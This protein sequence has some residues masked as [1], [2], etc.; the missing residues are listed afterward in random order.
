[1][2]LSA[3]LINYNYGRFLSEALD[4]LLNQT[5]KDYDVVFVDDAST[6]NSM[7]IA[8]K[9]GAIYGDR[10]K[11]FQNEKN[12]GPCLTIKRAVSLAQGE[13]VAM[14]A[15]DDKW[16][17]TF[18]EEVMQRTEKHPEVAICCTNSATF[19]SKST[20]VVSYGEKF[21]ILQPHQ[22]IERIKSSSF[23]I[24]SQT[25]IYKKEIYQSVQWDIE[26]GYM[27]DWYVNYTIACQYPVAC[28]PR[29]LSW[30]RIHEPRFSTT[31]FS[32]KEIKNKTYAFLFKTLKEKKQLNKF[33]K[34]SGLL[35]SMTRHMFYYV[36]QKPLLWQYMPSMIARRLKVTRC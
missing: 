10:L 11:I 24:K 14:C 6:D 7:E 5:Y 20:D 26:L 21:E 15:S 35:S 3:I 17:L 4:C 13:Y 12:M 30:L 36:A 2:K 1:M 9:Y 8:Q 34:K 27:C 22:T 32:N 33:V 19:D 16:E 18:F 31:A 23:L 25:A 29:T 28:L